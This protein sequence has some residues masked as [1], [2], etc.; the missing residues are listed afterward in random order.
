MTDHVLRDGRGVVKRPGLV[1]I[2]DVAP[3]RRVHVVQCAI[4]LDPGVVDQNAD[5]SE[6]A[7]DVGDYLF[8]A[9]EIPRIRLEGDRHVR[10]ALGRGPISG[11]RERDLVALRGTILTERPSDPATSS[12]Y[13]RDAP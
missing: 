3:S 12:G 13:P 4:A 5:R 2:D 7:L 11:V 10:Q 8:G 1:R 9:S 6:P